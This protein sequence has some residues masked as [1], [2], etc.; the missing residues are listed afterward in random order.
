MKGGCRSS[1]CNVIPASS[2]TEQILFPK[3]CEQE[4]ANGGIH[5]KPADFGKPGAAGGG[6]PIWA[7]GAGDRDPLFPEPN[8]GPPKPFNGGTARCAALLA[9]VSSYRPLV[10]R[11]RRTCRMFLRSGGYSA[12]SVSNIH[13]VYGLLRCRWGGNEPKKWAG[14]RPGVPTGLGM[15]KTWRR[16]KT[17]SD[18]SR[19]LFPCQLLCAMQV[20]VSAEMLHLWWACKGRPEG[21][22]TP[23]PKGDRQLG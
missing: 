16:C 5:R 1:L 21:G 7:R 20:M 6:G 2:R 13:K 15:L 23:G 11:K 22:M 18:S 3:L 4:A 14:V 9:T 10:A 17:S 19:S 8:V 12:I